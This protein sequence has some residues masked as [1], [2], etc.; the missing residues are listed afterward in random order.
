MSASTY[1]VLS[2]CVLFNCNIRRPLQDSSSNRS[3]REYSNAT[4]EAKET[5]YCSEEFTVIP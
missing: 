5:V 3:H 4:E 1:T 2:D